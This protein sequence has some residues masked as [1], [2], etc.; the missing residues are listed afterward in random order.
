MS[1][2]L[3][4]VQKYTNHVVVIQRSIGLPGTDDT[5]KIKDTLVYLLILL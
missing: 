4:S 5:L 1:V 3:M 2:L